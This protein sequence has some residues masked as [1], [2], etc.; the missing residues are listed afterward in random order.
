MKKIQTI[1]LKEWAE[2]FKN[3]LVL[4]SVIFLPL[5]MAAIPLGAFYAMGRDAS[6]EGMTMQDIPVEMDTFCPPELEGDECFQVYMVSQFMIMFMILPLAIPASIASYSV[7]G[8]KKARSLEPLLATPIKTIELLAG[9]GLS[10]LLPAVLATYLA[11]AVFVVGTRLLIPNDL[12]FSAVVDARWLLAVI[13]VGPLLALMAVSF[14]VMVSSRVNEPR[15]A[16]QI[17]MIMILPLM[18][19]LFAQIAGLFVIDSRLVI[20][21]AVLLVVLDAILAYMAVRVFQREAILTRWK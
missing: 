17:S 13:V 8:E 4:F 15:V 18:A 6:L 5:I 9:K 21:F 10:A 7:V 16:E 2:I 19:I 1:V 20:V 11:F 12:F 3:R 14:S